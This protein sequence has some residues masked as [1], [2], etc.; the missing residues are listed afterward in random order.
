MLLL[1]PEDEEVE[2]ILCSFSAS[3]GKKSHRCIEMKK[4]LGKEGGALPK[5][6]SL[7]RCVIGCNPRQRGPVAIRMPVPA[8]WYRH[9]MLIP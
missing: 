3:F 8:H 2:A 6:H 1:A 5:Y 9:L 7:T 4:P